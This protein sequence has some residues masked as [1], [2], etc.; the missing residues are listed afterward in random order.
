MLRLVPAL[1]ASLIT[2]PADERGPERQKLIECSEMLNF[3][4]P[5][6]AK[7]LAP[8]RLTIICPPFCF[9]LGCSVLFFHFVPVRCAPRNPRLW[10]PLPQR[11]YPAKT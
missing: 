10:R 3:D 8:S 9:V 6:P 11:R 4:S 7:V 2:F 5:N 1:A